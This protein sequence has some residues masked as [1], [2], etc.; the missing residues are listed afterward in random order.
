MAIENLSVLGVQGMTTEALRASEEV[1]SAERAAAA[2]D[3]KKVFF[4]KSNIQLVQNSQLKIILYFGGSKC[5]PLHMGDLSSITSVTRS[6][7]SKTCGSSIRLPNN[8]N[9]KRLSKAPL[10][11]R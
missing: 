4:T 1:K 8:I 2:Q 9:I 7:I 11:Y 3:Y 5:Y 10:D 6:Q